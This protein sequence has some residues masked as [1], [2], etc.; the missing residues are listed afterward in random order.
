MAVRICDDHPVATRGGAYERVMLLRLTG[1]T[2]RSGPTIYFDTH[3]QELPVTPKYPLPYTSVVFCC[4]LI[5]TIILKGRPSTAG[6]A[7]PHIGRAYHS[8]RQTAPRSDFFWPPFYAPAHCGF[9]SVVGLVRDSPGYQWGRP[10]RKDELSCLCPTRRGHNQTSVRIS[11]V[12]PVHTRPWCWG[13]ASSSSPR[14]LSCPRPR[15]Q[16]CNR[17]TQCR[18]LERASHPPLQEKPPERVKWRRRPLSRQGSPRRLGDET[19][20]L[21][22]RYRSPYPGGRPGWGHSSS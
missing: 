10:P 12:C 17:R 13:K 21:H 16:S 7:L 11:T 18:A 4:C 9:S 14:L 22:R 5:L 1:Q 3:T 6:A 2:R 8:T 20:G 15:Q 19:L